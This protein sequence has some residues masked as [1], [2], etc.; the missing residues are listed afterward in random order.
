MHRSTG[1]DGPCLRVRGCSSGVEAGVV[2]GG[3][4][5]DGA[6]GVGGQLDGRAGRRHPLGLVVV[7]LVLLQ[8]LVGRLPF[9]L[10][11]VRHVVRCVSVR[12]WI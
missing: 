10:R 4:E 2:D 1:C 12:L 5:G 7:L 8:L 3:A 11:S 6:L 9:L